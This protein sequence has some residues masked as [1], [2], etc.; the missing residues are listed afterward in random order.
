MA[1]QKAA[2]RDPPLWVPPG[3]GGWRGTFDRTCLHLGSA[4]RKRI[5]LYTRIEELDLEQTIRDGHRLSDQLIEPLF[6]HGAVALIVH[7]TAVCCVRRLSI[8]AHAAPHR[9]RRCRAEF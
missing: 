1:G 9:R 3:R 2:L 4:E 5:R 8:E 7:V 6:G